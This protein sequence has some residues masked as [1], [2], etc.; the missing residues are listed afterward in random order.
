MIAMSQHA[1]YEVFAE[2]M[3][4]LADGTL[5]ELE[6]LAS[7]MPPFPKGEDS[8]H[9]SPWITN[10]IQSGSRQAIYW[11]LGREVNLNSVDPQGCTPLHAAIERGSDDKYEIIGALLK[12]GAPVNLHGINVVDDYTPA[13]LAAA[14]D[15]VGSLK[16]LVQYGADLQIRTRIDRFATP[17]EEAEYLGAMNALRYLRELQANLHL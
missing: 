13:H 2:A 4:V 8:F 14:R 16:L 17:L 9:G 11:I 1:D 10:A 5:E 12:G 3:K 6:S 15:D 7:R